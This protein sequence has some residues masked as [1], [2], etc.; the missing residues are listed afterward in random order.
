MAY[1]FKIL[2]EE[3]RG[4]EEWLKKEYMTLRTGIASP[5]VLDG[6][7]ID[8]YG[9]RLPLNQ[10]ANIGIEDARTLR[11]TPWDKNQ[12]KEIEKAI[13]IANIGVSVGVDEK[14]VRVF[15]PELTGERRELLIKTAKA[16]LEDA[17]INVRGLRDNV[18]ADIQEKEKD[19]DIGEDDK[20][21]Y[22]SEMQKIID[23]ANN[24]LESLLV[25][26][27]KEINS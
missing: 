13:T 4:V 6:V 3:I 8:S 20:F 11:I 9:T 25:K 14:G 19:G 10:V 18:W 12:T 15:F 21:R 5:S 16:K 22:K 2:K 1:D 17:K 23:E 26:K 27:E 24:N 7:H